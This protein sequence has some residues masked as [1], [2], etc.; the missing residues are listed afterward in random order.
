MGQLWPSY[1]CAVKRF[2]TEQPKPFIIPENDPRTRHFV[3]FLATFLDNSWSTARYAIL[4]ISKISKISCY[5]FDAEILDRYY[6]IS[7]FYLSLID[8]EN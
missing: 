7:L 4:Q 3:P 6:K 5:I 2:S 8:A 1:Y